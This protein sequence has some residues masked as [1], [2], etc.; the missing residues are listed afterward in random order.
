MD[1]DY[2]TTPP[3]KI[4][5]RWLPIPGFTGYDVSDQGRVRSYWRRSGK[6]SRRNELWKPSSSP[7]RILKPRVIRKYPTVCLS[8]F[9]NLLLK[10]QRIEKVHRLVLI[11]FVGPC[12]PGHEG[13]HKDG[14]PAHCS[15]ENLEWGT[16]SKNAL[17]KFKHGYS[18]P[19]GVHNGR[20]KLSN[21]EVL[22]I[23]KLYGHGHL[24]ID[25]A[26]MFN[27][28]VPNVSHIVNRK[29]WTHI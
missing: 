11:T 13:C 7:Q 2:S 3:G 19:K 20:R 16:K 21:E 8:R 6:G 15:L 4:P 1:T 22:E 28:G 17:D 18:S 24:Q 23:R 29:T 25:I 9:G 12:P 27:I 26:K 14:V 10:K 5:E